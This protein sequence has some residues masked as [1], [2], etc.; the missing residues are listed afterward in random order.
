VENVMRTTV[1]IPDD[2]A[3]EAQELTEGRSLS[4]FTRRALRERVE[5]L[6]AERLA[7]QLEEGYRGEA[8]STSLD[9]EWSDLEA[10]GL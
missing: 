4:E 1:T 8:E 9:P 2:L 5:R 10:E 7:C 6:K 3:R